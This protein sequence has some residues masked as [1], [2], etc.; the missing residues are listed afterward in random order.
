M[1]ASASS[2]RAA[3]EE[4]EEFVML[5]M[6]GVSNP[7]TI[8][9][10][11]NDKLNYCSIDDEGLGLIAPA[12]S[13][14]SLLADLQM[15]NNQISDEGA[16]LIAGVLNNSSTIR[17]VDLRGNNIGGEGVQ[18]IASVIQVRN[19]IEQLDLSDNP[20][21]NKGAI[22]IGMALMRNVSISKLF[23]QNCMIG[24]GGAR[25]LAK[26]LLVP[27][28]P[29]DGLEVLVLAGNP[30]NDD[31]VLA[32]AGALAS[33]KT[34]LVNLDLSR[35]YVTDKG[36]EALCEASSRPGTRVSIV[37]NRA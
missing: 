12:L 5:D 25:T 20:I 15:A 29:N 17:Y 7:K 21:Q 35:T 19:V 8:A 28:A 24:D 34:H 23:L 33:G 1:G 4:E 9:Q 26:S 3:Q 11:I 16:R 30:I 22:A 27:K 31:G 37:A 2:S 14:C 6:T 13:K 10:K 32:L 18:Y 36:I